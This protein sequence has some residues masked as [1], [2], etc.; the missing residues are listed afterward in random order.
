MPH[1]REQHSALGLNTGLANKNDGQGIYVSTW[2]RTPLDSAQGRKLTVDLLSSLYTDGKTEVR[3]V[4]QGHPAR[5]WRRFEPALTQTLPWRVTPWD[6]SRRPREKVQGVQPLLVRHPV[7]GNHG[8]S[9]PNWHPFGKCLSEASAAPSVLAGAPVWSRV[10]LG[11]QL[12][13][14]SYS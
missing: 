11:V 14:A 7:P 3:E 12:G 8:D 1:N 10:N 13:S 9:C 6:P 4:T 2:D 5:K